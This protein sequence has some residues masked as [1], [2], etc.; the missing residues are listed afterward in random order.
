MKMYRWP[1]TSRITVTDRI[2][3][4]KKNGKMPGVFPGQPAIDF[5]KKWGLLVPGYFIMPR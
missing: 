4:N 1:I 3:G 5:K 2:Y